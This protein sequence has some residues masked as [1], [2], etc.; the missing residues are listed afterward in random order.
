[1]PMA[2]EFLSLP[3]EL[4]CH[5][6][7]LL[8]PR[9][10][11]RCA[12]TCNTFLVAVRNSVEIQYKLEIYAQGLISTETAT[13]ASVNSDSISRKMC[14]LK[15]LA[16]LWQSDFYANTIFE[17]MVTAAIPYIPIVPSPIQSVKCGPWWTDPFSKFCDRDYRMRPKLSLTWSI[18]DPYQQHWLPDF[19]TFDPVQDLIVMFSSPDGV[20]VTNAEQD[21]HVF[22][23]EFVLGS[24]HCPHPNA[25]RAALEC[26]HTF[27]ASGFYC[28]YLAA[29]PIICG[30][31]VFVFYHMGAVVSG[32]FI[33]VINW[34]KGYANNVIIST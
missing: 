12:M 13:T 17:T 8:N 9:D 26:K 5:I 19:I 23:V 27:N 20:T 29:K 31:H 32:T 16:S 6:L 1:M 33:Q 18:N 22:S 28:A 14:S 30:D 15:K 34:R 24:S 21:H 25:A 7:I 4:I 3:T 10:I 11:S 2:V